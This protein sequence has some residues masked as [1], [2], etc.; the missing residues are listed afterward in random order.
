MLEFSFLLVNISG[1]IILFSYLCPLLL[2]NLSASI[3][4]YSDYY[5]KIANYA[6]ALNWLNELLFKLWLLPLIIEGERFDELSP[7]TKGLWNKFGES[8]GI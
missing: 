6:V 3:N 8:I 2:L 4:L 1:S 7:L 5:P